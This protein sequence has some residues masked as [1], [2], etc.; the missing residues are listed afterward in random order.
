M[1]N[2]IKEI[3]NKYLKEED[4]KRR[5]EAE[6]NPTPKISKGTKPIM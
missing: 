5:T 3:K 4:E 6:Y 1:T 2:D